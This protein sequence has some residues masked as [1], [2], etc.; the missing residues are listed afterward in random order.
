MGEGWQGSLR[1]IWIFSGMAEGIYAKGVEFLEADNVKISA[2]IKFSRFPKS[3]INL[4]WK[5][6]FTK[7]AL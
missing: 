4:H 6:T 1:P 7:D 3:P 5:E 2:G